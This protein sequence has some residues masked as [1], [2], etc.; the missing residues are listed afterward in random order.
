MIVSQWHETDLCHYCGMVCEVLVTEEEEGI[1]YQ[2]TEC[3]YAWESDSHS[4]PVGS[5]SGPP[6]G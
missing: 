3:G 5:I 1:S 6:R 4:I 2:C